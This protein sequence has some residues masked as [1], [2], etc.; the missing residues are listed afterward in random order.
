MVAIAYANDDLKVLAVGS[1][2]TLNHREIS[3]LLDGSIS[4]I[5]HQLSRLGITVELEYFHITS[6]QVIHETITKSKC[7]AIIDVT[8][9]QG[10]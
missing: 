6:E 2:N 5:G 1:D 3:E 8:F 7:D 9:H 10:Y 4:Q